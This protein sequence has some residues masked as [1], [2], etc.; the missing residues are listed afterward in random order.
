MR[1]IMMN[2]WE[3]MAVTGINN[4]PPHATLMPFDSVD[5]ASVERDTSPWFQTLNG[6]WK[7]RWVRTPEERPRTFFEE[8]YD[9]CDW[10]DM[11]VPG[12]WQ[13]K[14][15][16]VPIYSNYTYPFEMDP[17]RIHGHNGNPVGSY[18]RT[19]E[20][21]E[22]WDER[23][24]FIHFEG[25]DSAFYLWINGRFVG[26]SQDSRTPGEFHI[27]HYLKPG[28]NTVSVQVFRWC[29]GSYLEDQDG[30]RM[31]GIFRDVFL[32]STPPVHIRDFFVKPV[33]DAD[34]R[35]AIVTVEVSLKNYGCCRSTDG[36]VEVILATGNGDTVASSN[37][38]CGALDEGEEQRLEL[39]MTVEAPDTWTPDTPRLYAVYVVLM[40]VDGAVV[41]VVT[42]RTGFRTIEVKGSRI[43]LNGHPIK[44]KGVNRVEH[45]PVYGKT[46]PLATTI[47]DLQLMKRHNIDTVRTAHFPNH[48]DLYR[49]CDEY[50]VMVID[51]AN[52]ESH[53]MFFGVES[54]AKQPQ[55]R[56]QHVER[57]AAM[58]ERDKNHPCVIM[59]S[60]GNEAGNGT[61]MV[62]MNDYCHERDPSRPTHYHIMQEPCSCDVMGGGTP[63]GS[64]YKRYLSLEEL[65][66]V[67]ASDDPRPYLLNEY[68]HA[69]GN[70]MGNLQEYVELF[71]REPKLVGGCLWDWV[72]QGLAKEGPDGKTFFA[73]GGDYGDTPND[74]TFCFNGLV[75]SDRETTAKTAEVQ[76]VFQDLTFT[77]VPETETGVEIFNRSFFQDTSGYTFRWALCGNG[78][79]IG[80]GDVRV[81]AIAPRARVRVDVPCT[82]PDTCHAVEY[83]LML[84]AHLAHARPWAA[85]GHRVAW[86]QFVLRPWAFVTEQPEAGGDA[87]RLT[88]T[89]DTLRI[90]GDGV[91]ISFDRASGHLS[92]YCTAGGVLLSDGPVFAPMRATINNDRK[93]VEELQLFFEMPPV[94]RKM[95]AAAGEAGVTVRIVKRHATV[96]TDA[97][98][99]KQKLTPEQ[100]EIG[101]D[102]TETYGVFADGTVELRSEVSPFGPL[103]DLVRIGYELVSPAGFD[104][105]SWYGRGSHE[106][107]ADRQC[108]A[109][110]GLYAGTV[111]EQFVN[112]PYPQENGNK[113]D[114]RWLTLSN[115]QGRTIRIQGMQPLS[116]SVRH[117]TTQN[118]NDAAH[119]YDLKRI[120]ET[121]ISVDY[122]QGPLGNASCGPK[123]LD[124]YVIPKE[125]VQFGFVLK[126]ALG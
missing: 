55:W 25:V 100:A 83:T 60:H 121:V 61:N 125:P 31:A 34:Y 93:R 87:L 69:M 21:P 47:R 89:E 104:A 96:L 78:R 15:Y 27:S 124:K 4:E 43:L 42:C 67:A 37:V 94:V 49:L 86:E 113:T 16:D 53:G 13:M 117:Y 7:F 88:D 110:L 33:L 95:E 76:K 79:P 123:P 23:E 2:D 116:V 106:S 50:G 63:T 56:Q 102:V 72:D 92:E 39:C 81:P 75:F 105:F 109:P 71:E 45:H 24:T 46:V 64:P 118:L 85:R 14:G 80:G 73:Y 98:C 54:L 77:R 26:Y 82:L 126:V 103:P 58:V 6:T 107:Y 91:A 9:V 8:G 1:K 41:E 19:F 114:V 12:C 115:A 36:A 70:A 59:W 18:H 57:A 122:R 35:D 44:I 84:S 52:V 90:V 3:N 97:M 112:Y 111:D 101:F 17:P 32:F 74:G 29:D 20:L 99:E 10:D 38:A 65:E 11:V 40:G 68:A 119:P 28:H 66:A 51:E 62:A 48:P 30:W 108:G 22:S 5:D 120:A